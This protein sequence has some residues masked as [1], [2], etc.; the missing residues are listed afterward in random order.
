MM[1]IERSRAADYRTPEGTITAFM[2]MWSTG[3]IRR[4]YANAAL[5]S[6]LTSNTAE[7]HLLLQQAIAEGATLLDTHEV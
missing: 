4:T 1:F 7:A 6:N 5:P 2:H 3:V